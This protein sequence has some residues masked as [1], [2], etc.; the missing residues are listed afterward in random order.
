MSVKLALLK[1]GEQVIADVGELVDDNGILHKYIFDNP[2]IVKFLTAEYLYEN[3]VATEEEIDHKVSFCPWIPL[4][5]DTRMAVT[6]DWVVTIVE[7]NEW[8]RN[9]YEAK[10]NQTTQGEVNDELPISPT[11]LSSVEVLSE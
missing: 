9:S 6:T 7:P 11:E 4:T 3:A 10:M 2:Y 8:I 1:S 5:S